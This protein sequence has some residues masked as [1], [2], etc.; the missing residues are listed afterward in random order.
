MGG[1]QHTVQ[2]LKVLMVDE[3]NGLVVV[4]GAVSGPKGCLVK[5]QDAVKK[6]WPEIPVEHPPSGQ[7]AAEPMKAAA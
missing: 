7:E 3:E 6:P 4:N 1:E 5:I 2:N